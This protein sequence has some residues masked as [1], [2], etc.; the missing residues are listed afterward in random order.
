MN[1]SF[2]SPPKRDYLIIGSAIVALVLDFFLPATR[3]ILIV[4]A[5]IGSLPTVWEGMRGLLKF[6][7]T[8][9]AFNFVALAVSFGLGEYRSTAF[10]ILMLSSASILEW[11]TASR[12]RN[13]VKELLALKPRTAVIEKDGKTEE[14][15]ADDLR[16]GDTVVLTAGA[17]VPAD[18]VVIYGSIF[19]NESS[20]TGES[21]PVEKV[22]GDKVLSGT[23]GDSGAV[24]IRVT[25]VGKE[26]TLERMVELIKEAA[27]NKSKNE[28]LADRF[29]AIF[30][31]VV[32]VVGL[33]T[34]Y[35]S[36]NANMLASIF[37]VAC[38]DDMA[39][40]IP[41]AVSAAIGS[42]AKRGVVVK[43]GE[44]LDVLSRVRTVVLDKTGTLTFGNFLLNTVDIAEGVNETEFW[45][46]VGSTERYSEH[47]VGRAI[48]KEAL[49]HV[50]EI[51]E[52]EN[53]VTMKG[54][55]VKA[56]LNG[57]NILV[58]DESILDQL[59]EAN[60]N[61][62]QKALDE[63]KSKAETVAIVAIDG[64]YSGSL[65]IADTPRPEARESLNLLRQSGVSK[66]AIFTGDNEK[67]AQAIAN[68]M[69]VD[70]VFSSMSPEDKLKRLE[71]LTGPVAMVGDGIND[72]PALARADVS[73]A[74]GGGGT[75][76]A[77]EAADIVILTDNLSRIPE[78]MVLGKRTVS[79]IHWDVVIW[80]V[81]NA[82]GFGLVFAGL[83]G[84]AMAAFYNFMTD[85]LPLANSA[86]L[87]REQKR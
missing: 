34:Y 21:V 65:G 84:P 20:V 29:A 58:G 6:T 57:H 30:L 31:P 66:I 73:I 9:E 1:S 43:G 17:R 35:F 72:A 80:V 36:H 40:A 77:V 81:T 22:V 41:L 45:Q 71:S 42:A 15:S 79:V 68:T 70:E 46:S 56:Q 28:R 23:L 32:L 82:L 33:A 85:F 53:M 76:V 19:I 37:L 64:V 62:A 2:F 18:G 8:I 13:A 69:K 12:T 3:P 74:M 87:F 86:R 44:W 48:Y 54:S 14:V 60:K 63:L 50:K 52:C 59:D 75:A 11:R 38:A 26:S 55:G 47:P 25:H 78:M 39:V 51:P 83:I 67:V 7:I 5:A 10:I 4:V 27:K 49:R 16:E 24:K 61:K